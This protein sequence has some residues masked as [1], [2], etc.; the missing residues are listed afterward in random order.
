VIE[1]SARTRL[2]GV[3]AGTTTT[4]EVA[5]II[6]EA[7]GIEAPTIAVVRR[8]GIGVPPGAVAVATGGHPRTPS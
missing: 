3:E 4:G 1:A 5:A 6:I 7:A 2:L 8:P